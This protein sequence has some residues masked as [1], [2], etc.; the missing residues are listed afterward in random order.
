MVSGAAGAACIHARGRPSVGGQS[1]AA[2]LTALR[3]NTQLGMYAREHARSGVTR[4]ELAEVM[5]QV[6]PYAGFPQM[7]NALAIL[8]NAAG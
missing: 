3:A 2:A 8:A 4:E 7:L 6:G 5:V 1:A